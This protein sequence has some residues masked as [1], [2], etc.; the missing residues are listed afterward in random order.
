MP[1]IKKPELR[2]PIKL[3]L[4]HRKLVA[5]VV[6]SFADCLKLD[7]PN[8]RII[9]FNVAELKKLKETAENDCV[10]RGAARRC[11]SRGELPDILRSFSFLPPAPSLLT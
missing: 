10:T 2:F 6:P 1:R 9:D 4:A 7:E 8:P 3:T 11:G 5:E